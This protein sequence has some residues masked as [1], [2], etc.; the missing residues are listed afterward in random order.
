MCDIDCV[1][2]FLLRQLN[3]SILLIFCRQSCVVVCVALPVRYYAWPGP[4]SDPERRYR[5]ILM[6]VGRKVGMM[7][8]GNSSGMEGYHSLRILQHSLK[9]FF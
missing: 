4:V 6:S 9:L 1:W 5:S 3:I 8:R 2:E 7:I